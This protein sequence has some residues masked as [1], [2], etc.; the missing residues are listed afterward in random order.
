MAAYVYYIISGAKEVEKNKKTSAGSNELAD[1][2]AA[3]R[4]K[5]SYSTG[6]LGKGFL[7]DL[8]VIDPKTWR[9]AAVFVDGIQKV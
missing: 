2:L 4:N 5:F 1:Y 6:K 3:K 7:A 9:P 8:A